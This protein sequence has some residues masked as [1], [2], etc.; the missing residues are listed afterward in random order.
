MTVTIL[1]LL[2]PALIAWVPLALGRYPG[3]AAIG[4][5]VARRRARNPALRSRPA[6]PRT[7]RAPERTTPHGGLLLARWL[8][9]RGPP[10]SAFAAR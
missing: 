2:A 4:R 3:E 7:P 1:L 6:K 5:A 9:G 8:A 10:S